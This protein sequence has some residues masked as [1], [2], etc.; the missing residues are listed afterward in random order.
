MGFLKVKVNSQLDLKD[1]VS[2]Q[3]SSLNVKVNSLR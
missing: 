1:K 2:F 3:M